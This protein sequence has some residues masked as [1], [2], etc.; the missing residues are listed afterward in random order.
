MKASLRDA[1][2]Q[3][4]FRIDDD[5]YSD[6]DFR[7]MSIDELERVKLRINKK[8]SNLSA[9]IV[10]EKMDYANGKKNAKNDRLV[11]R[12]AALSINER[13]SAYVKSLIAN[14][15][16][17]GKTTGDS[18]LILPCVPKIKAPKPYSVLIRKV[19]PLTTE[20]EKFLLEQNVA[21]RTY[22]ELAAVFNTRFK[23]EFTR[24]QIKNFYYKKGI[25]NGSPRKKDGHCWTKEE[26][27][28]LSKQGEDKIDR[29]LTVLINNAFNLSLTTQQ[30]RYACFYYKIK[31]AKVPSKCTKEIKSFIL[32]NSNQKASSLTRM[33]NARF[34]TAF[35]LN[36]VLH[37]AYNSGLRRENNFGMPKP[38]Y[39][40]KII[41]GY[42]AIKIAMTG[43]KRTL[44]KEKHR[45]VWEKVHGKIPEGMV[46]IFLDNNRNNFALKNLAMVSRAEA[47]K[48]SQFGFRSGNKE[49]TLAGLAIVR[50][51]MAVHERL[52]ERLGK[53][54]HK[55]FIDEVSRKRVRGRKRGD[56]GVMPN[57]FL[58]GKERTGPEA[59]RKEQPSTL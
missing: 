36:Q 56:I 38:L 11:N 55:L 34:G 14:R 41:K 26:L 13:V 42:V 32:E 31:R 51:L 6:A 43:P 3:D 10:K 58:K 49:K 46:I 23:T 40:E 53:K 25:K 18:F 29:E 59:R 1:I 7:A 5:Q 57:L 50:Y 30:V 27:S 37:A 39:S 22:S 21:G 45:W 2:D 17:S 54:G 8:I 4:V 15:L 19:N 47:V 20:Q 44:W 33:V 12:R 24:V 16:R 48:L 52:K 28:F 35:T 9:A